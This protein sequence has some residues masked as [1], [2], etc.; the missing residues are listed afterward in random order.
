[1]YDSA[2]STTGKQLD[3]Y[4]ANSGFYR[5]RAKAVGIKPEM[6]VPDLRTTILGAP[7]RAPDQAAIQAEL[8]RRGLIK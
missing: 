5:D 7:S 2:L 3:V 4:E 8:K 1:M 6:V